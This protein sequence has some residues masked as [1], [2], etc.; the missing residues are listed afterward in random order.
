MLLIHYNARMNK[1]QVECETAF[2]QCNVTDD[3]CE[4]AICFTEGGFSR[5]GWTNKY[6]ISDSTTSFEDV[7]TLYQGAA[8]CGIEPEGGPG[9]PVGTVTIKEQ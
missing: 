7:L 4:K 8:D 5:W 9:V 1:T 6:N 2:A 3:I